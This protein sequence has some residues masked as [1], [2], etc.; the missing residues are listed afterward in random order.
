MR[1][2]LDELRASIKPGVNTV[3]TPWG[4][5][6]AQAIN[7]IEHLRKVRDAARAINEECTGDLPPSLGSLARL[8][9]AL[10]SEWKA[11]QNKDTM[12]MATQITVNGTP[13]GI[14]TE[15]LSYA[16]IVVLAGSPPDRGDLTITYWTKGEGDRHRSGTV[17]PGRSIDVEDGMHFTAVNT[18]A[19]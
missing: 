19:A 2:V 4:E 1:D 6:L 8:A 16:D 13:F 3:L 14:K 11:R 9:D 18:S 7:E 10:H 15:F 12:A 5:T 17:T